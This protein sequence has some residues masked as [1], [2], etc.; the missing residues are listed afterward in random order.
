MGGAPR[1]N[2]ANYIGEI[3]GLRCG[4]PPPPRGQANP[5]PGPGAPPAA[6]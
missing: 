4:A 3:P 5:T 1:G 6:A 2:A